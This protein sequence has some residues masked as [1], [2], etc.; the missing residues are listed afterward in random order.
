[1]KIRKIFV[2]SL[3]SLLLGCASAV[4]DSDN[5]L[6]E[7]P[8][9]RKTNLSQA[10]S[11][12]KDEILRSKDRDFGY[13]FV[14]DDVIDGTV[15]NGGFDG[16]LSDSL[17]Y[18]LVH[19][20][21]QAVHQGY[22]IV[23]ANF[24]PVLRRDPNNSFGLDEN[25]MADKTALKKLEKFYTDRINS[26]RDK[27]RKDV[28]AKAKSLGSSEVEKI[29]D[30]RGLNTLIVKA[31]FTRN[32][33][34]PVKKNSLGLNFG[35]DGRSAKSE[36][37]LGRTNQ[38]KSMT[39]TVIVEDPRRNEIRTSASFTINTHEEGYAIDFSGGYG[40]AFLGFT[41]DNLLVESKHG[42][43]Q[44]LIDAATLWLLEYTFGN[45][46]N[47]KWCKHAKVENT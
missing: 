36:I 22:G 17:R 14:I 16:E 9:D 35:A 20:L 41:N 10:L 4:K 26:V 12:A 8:G 28:E 37:D 6:I 2:L 5:F 40:D 19:N 46:S 11:C 31:A 29:S 3:C 13:L 47:M 15:P 23:L 43:Q 30:Y 27:S 25:S 45:V 32:D 7:K 39:L 24:P 21:K 18:E 1:M 33:E 38:F 34:N 44:T 42:A